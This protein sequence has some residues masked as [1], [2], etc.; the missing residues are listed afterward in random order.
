PPAPAPPSPTR[1]SSDLREPTDRHQGRTEFLDGQV[2][3]QVQVADAGQEPEARASVGA[4]LEEHIGLSAPQLAPAANP[5]AAGRQ[6]GD[7]SEEHTSELQSLAY[8]V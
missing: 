8:L 6:A 5:D 3:V 7:R 2:L 4:T 1:R